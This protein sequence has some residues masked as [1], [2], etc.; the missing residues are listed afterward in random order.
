[1]LLSGPARMPGQLDVE[2]SLPGLGS[3]LPGGLDQ[4]AHRPDERHDVADSDGRVD[5]AGRRGAR[6]E[7]VDRC[8]YPARGG[9]VGPAR[10]RSRLA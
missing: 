2:E 5:R 6:G 10:W 4:A 1:M 8:S 9:G 3:D 7:L